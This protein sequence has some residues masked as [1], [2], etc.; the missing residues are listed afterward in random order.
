MLY[1]LVQLSRS[2]SVLSS[3]LCGTSQEFQEVAVFLWNEADDFVDIL[4]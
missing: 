3:P 2:V 4:K 1:F